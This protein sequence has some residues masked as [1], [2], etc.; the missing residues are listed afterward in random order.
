MHTFLHCRLS[1]PVETWLEAPSRGTRTW[2]Y[3]AGLG[4]R[5]F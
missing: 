2:A 3:P 1:D 5:K 4:N